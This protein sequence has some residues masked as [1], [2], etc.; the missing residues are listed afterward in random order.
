MP[1]DSRIEEAPCGV[2]RTDDSGDE[3]TQGQ[4]LL[5][6]FRPRATFGSSA[7]GARQ[8]TVDDMKDATVTHRK[9]A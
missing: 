4:D 1:A 2:G 8:L 9:P 5:P 3:G 7:G 6:R